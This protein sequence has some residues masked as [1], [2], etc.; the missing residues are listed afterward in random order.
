MYHICIEGTPL[1]DVPLP[2][3]GIACCATTRELAEAH[4]AE[5][6]RRFSKRGASVS[7][8]AGHCPTPQS[9]P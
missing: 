1:C 4:A 2:H 8:R 3:D 7:V 9:R 5:A 6:R